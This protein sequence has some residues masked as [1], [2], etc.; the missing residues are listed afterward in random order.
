MIGYFERRVQLDPE[1][2]QVNK[3]TKDQAEHIVTE[4]FDLWKRRGQYD[5][6]QDLGWLMENRNLYGLSKDDVERATSS[7]A[8]LERR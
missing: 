5:W 1:L 3:L 2:M 7:L 4:A 8:S 6:S